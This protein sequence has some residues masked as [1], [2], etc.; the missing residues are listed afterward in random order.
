MITHIKPS[1]AIP[2]LKATTTNSGR[3]YQIPSGEKYPSIT[4]MLGH[5]EKPWLADWQNMLGANKAAKETKRCSDRGTAVHEMVEKFLNNEEDP[6]KGYSPDHIKGFNQ[7]KFKLK[8]VD[9]I[10]TQEASLYSK[11]LRIAGRVDC[12]GEYNGKLS[13]IDFKTSNGIKDR[14]MIEDYFLQC[15]AYA[16][17]WHELT[18]ESITNITVLM[19]VERGMVPLVF[20]DTIDKYVEPLLTRIAQYYRETT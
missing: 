5:K 14:D 2:E 18:N 17:M 13:I 16:I 1:V 3:T 15:T 4:T 9:N 6:T 11:Q 10:R 20:E 8:N 12:V 19:C 7:L